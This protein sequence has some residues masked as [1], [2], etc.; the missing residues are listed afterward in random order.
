MKSEGVKCKPGGTPSS[1]FV[2]SL[3]PFNEYENAAPAYGTEGLA[4]TTP[5]MSQSGSAACKAVA[6]VTFV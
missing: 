6:A 1:V 4:P 2:V 3:E 5:E